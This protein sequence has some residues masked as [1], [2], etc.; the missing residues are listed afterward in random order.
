MVRF[1]HERVLLIGDTDRQVHSALSQAAPG[2]QITAVKGI[3]D[4]IAELSGGSYTTVLA[5]AEPIERRPAAAVRALRDLLGEGRLLLYGHPTLEPLSRKMLEFGCDD[6]VVT[7]PTPTELQQIFGVP[8]LRLTEGETEAL[9]RPADDPVITTGPQTSVLLTLPLAEIMLDAM[10]QHPSAAPTAAVE[11][12]N[13]RIAP[14]MRLH[15]GKT[16]EPAP[17]ANDGF[18]VLSHPVRVQNEEVLALHL[19]LPVEEDEVAARHFMAQLSALMAKLT[20]LQDRHNRLQKLA[21]TDELTGLYNG[22]YFR[23]FLNRIVEKARLMR[24]PVTLLLFDIDNFKK[25]ND[26]F[27]H[28]VGDEILRQTAALMKKSCRDHD[29]V[30]RISGDEFAVVFWEK[31]GPRQP[32]EPNRGGSSSRVP[33]TI[34]PVLDRFRRT[35]ESQDFEF[36]GPGGKGQLTISGGL[37]VYPYDA[38]NVNDLIQAADHALMFGAKQSG[39]NSIFLVGG[40]EH[41]DESCRIE[42]AD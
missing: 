20:G 16:G 39:K 32:R 25:Y 36:L 3:F 5:A 22:R 13:Q 8:P 28:A 33:Q 10:L 2:A 27:G 35:L 31:E 37:A 6:Y 30:A 24:F 42:P 41:P 9:D 14:T 11:Q 4:A 21:I 12:I 18:R 17:T 1:A 26:R 7:P 38:H 34:M 23:H 19:L 15:A 29:L 40:N